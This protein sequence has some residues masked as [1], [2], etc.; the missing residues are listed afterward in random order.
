MNNESTDTGNQKKF[1][2]GSWTSDDKKMLIITIA[3]TVAANIITVIVVALAIIVARNFRP[4]PST[5]MSYVILLSS[6]TTPITII[7]I[8]LSARS[9]A[10]RAGSVAGRIVKWVMTIIAIATGFSILLI[11][12]GWIGFAVGVK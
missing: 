11:L 12:L 6:S 1:I 4:H 5:P 8:A 2:S 3:A 9:D 10:I 7:L